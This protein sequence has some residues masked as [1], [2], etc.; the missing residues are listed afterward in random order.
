VDRS[1]LEPAWT[2]AESL[3]GMVGPPGMLGRNF[4]V[5]LNAETVIK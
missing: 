3:A 2:L 5:S 1:I 4:L